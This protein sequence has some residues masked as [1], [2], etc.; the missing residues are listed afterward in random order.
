MLRMVSLSTVLGESG[1]VDPR[2]TEM[3]GGDNVT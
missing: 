3:K 2:L 1:L